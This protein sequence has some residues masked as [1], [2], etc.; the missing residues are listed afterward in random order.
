METTNNNLPATLNIS[1]VQSIIGQAPATLQANMTSRDNAVKAGNELIEASKNIGMSA[2]LDAKM[3]IYVEKARKSL[4]AI[5]DKRKPFTQMM[6]EVKKRFTEC[7]NDIKAK[8]DEVQK[9]RDDH[10]T[11]LMKEKL[12]KEEEERKKLEKEK[13]VIAVR[14]QIKT[15]LSEAFYNFVAEKKSKVNAI[16][17]SITLDTYNDIKA[18]LDS[19]VSI[20][21]PKALQDLSISVESNI[22]TADEIQALKSEISQDDSLHV[23]YASEYRNIMSVFQQEVRDKLPSKL[24]QL[25]ELSRADAAEAERIKN[26]EA[27]RQEE[28]RIKLENE[29]NAA[30]DNAIVTAAAE[31]AAETTQATMGA[32]F[33]TN[34]VEAPRVKERTEIKILNKAAYSLIFMFW[35]EKEGV[36]LDSE[37]IEK[38]TLAQM[39]KFCEDYAVST[40]ELIDSKLIEYV[41]VYKAK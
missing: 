26:E 31:A 5:N 25:E 17:D 6:D 37:K 28:E 16:F 30:I 12:A 13:E 7:E 27:A 41:D 39:K 23:H 36:N 21:T 38:K 9:I 40:G 8:A 24:T 35:F 4:K 15:K 32:L 29:K 20:F 14:Q 10:A 3:A 1:E 18:S 19:P 34:S 2:D 11:K 22:L 33:N